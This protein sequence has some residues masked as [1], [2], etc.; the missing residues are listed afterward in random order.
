M[1]TARIQIESQSESIKTTVEKKHFGE[2]DSLRGLAAVAVVLYHW[3]HLY[4]QHSLPTRIDR[5]LQ[6]TPLQLLIGG[7]SSVILFYVLSGFV[8]SLPQVRGARVDYPAYLIK[9]ICRIYLPYLIALI[10]SL[11]GCFYFH[12]LDSYDSWFRL[13]W[14][15]SPSWGLIRQHLL[16]VGDYDV[17]AYNTAF[18]SLV[19]EMRISIFFP[20]LC[21]AVI[22]LRA[23]GSILLGCSLVFLGMFLDSKSWIPL[24]Y[25]QTISSTSI[26]I[27]GILISLY[28]Q[29]IQIRL[30]SLPRAA[31]WA[32]LF[33]SLSLYIYSPLL[34]YHLY[35]AKPVMD[36]LLAL[37]SGG[38]VLFSLSTARIGRFL[39]GSTISFLGRISYS[40]YLIHGT[41]LFS[42]AYLFH[43]KLS[44][45][46]WFV[47]YLGVTLGAAALLH[48]FAE[49]PSIHLG[50]MFAPIVDRR[51]DQRSSV[52]LDHESGILRKAQPE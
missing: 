46:A 7:H 50:K 41:V 40:I 33:I 25:S 12:G 6:L 32:L 44:P 26:F 16:F 31:W 10:L 27:L 9:R 38:I 51:S 24:T 36:S 29:K 20:V 11:L 52:L 17:S 42:F 1:S 22:R 48:R 39:M 8:L 14:Y 43:G 4:P 45:V 21:F 3:Y 19:Q 2:L 34:G 18:W 13:T 5:L 47:P 30:R 28:L 37:G 15:A 49:L 23:A 35:L